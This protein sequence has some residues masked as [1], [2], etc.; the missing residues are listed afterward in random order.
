MVLAGGFDIMGAMKIW[1]RRIGIVLAGLLL[2]VVLISAMLP[3]EFSVIRRVTIQATPAE[4]HALVGDLSR[5]DAW[6]P[7]VDADPTVT[8]TLGRIWSGV[9]AT[10][11]WRGE[12][13]AG[14]LEVTAWDPLRGIDYDIWFDQSADRSRG[15]IHYQQGPE[16]TTVTWELTGTVPAP[17]VGGLFAAMMDP[18]VGP[19]LYIGLLN[20][21]GVI[22]TGHKPAL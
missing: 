19:M 11:Q 17:V 12:S 6:A 3:K 2:L 8:I 14:R 21:K 18:L 7:W 10:Q 13:G 5:W 4:V 20:L 1:L 9:G 16:G 22:E 15:T